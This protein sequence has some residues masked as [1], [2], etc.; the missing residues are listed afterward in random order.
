MRFH[1]PRYPETAAATPL[2]QQPAGGNGRLPAR[3]QCR[4]SDLDARSVAPIERAA[5]ANAPYHTHRALRART[6][7]KRVVN[8]LSDALRTPHGTQFTPKVGPVFPC[9]F[10]LD[11]AREQSLLNALCLPRVIIETHNLIC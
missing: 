6:R 3:T 9:F 5:R 1:F 4:D 2:R 8:A 11:L 10:E 7:P